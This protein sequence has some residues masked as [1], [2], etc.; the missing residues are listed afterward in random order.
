MK[1]PPRGYFERVRLSAPAI[2]AVRDD[3]LAKFA[4]AK[5]VETFLINTE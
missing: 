3:K 1:I 5:R 2:L 4:S